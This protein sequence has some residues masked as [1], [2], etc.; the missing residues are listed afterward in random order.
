VLIESLPDQRLDD[1]L[2]THIEILSCLVE[3]LQ[4]ADSDIHINALNR[5]DHKALTLEEMGD[6]LK[7]DG[8]QP[9]AHPTDRPPET[10]PER[11]IVDRANT[12][13]RTAPAPHRTLCLGADSPQ[14]FVLSH[15]EAKTHLM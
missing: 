11:R 10:A 8:I 3:F 2:A 4:H 5:L 14:A 9:I 7:Y 6:V 15:I 12:A 1:G 13:W